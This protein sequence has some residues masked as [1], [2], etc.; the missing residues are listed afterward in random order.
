MLVGWFFFSWTHY[1]ADLSI[2]LS[3]FLNTAAAGILKRHLLV[4]DCNVVGFSW[5]DPRARE[6]PF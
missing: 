1:L 3:I 6:D 2:Y 5:M 4:I